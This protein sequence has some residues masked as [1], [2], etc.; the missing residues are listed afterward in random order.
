MQPVG[1][2]TSSTGSRRCALCTTRVFG[3]FAA[4]TRRSLL[5]HAVCI[6][7]IDKKPEAFESFIR[8]LQTSTTRLRD[9]LTRVAIEPA[10]EMD[11]VLAL[12]TDP[13]SKVHDRGLA[14]KH[15]FEAL[16]PA[17]ERLYVL[18]LE[19][20][21]LSHANYATAVPVPQRYPPAT[22]TLDPQMPDDGWRADATC[23]DVF[24]LGLDAYSGMLEGDP[25]RAEIDALNR[26]KLALMAEAERLSAG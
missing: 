22:L 13:E 3:H 12:E 16:G 7:A 23:A 24:L 9:A 6:A 1:C 2:D 14:A 19:E 5:E 17:G 4:P 15:R 20:T 18:W 26:A 10:A 21:M 8:S 25:L 11:A